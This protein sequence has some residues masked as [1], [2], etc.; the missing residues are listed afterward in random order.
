MSQISAQ[1]SRFAEEVEERRPKRTYREIADESQERCAISG[2]PFDLYYDREDCE[3]FYRD[4]VRLKRRVGDARAGSLVLVG[5]LRKDDLDA[6]DEI[7]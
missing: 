5:A 1:G 3:W 6:N 7:R 2:D 4:A